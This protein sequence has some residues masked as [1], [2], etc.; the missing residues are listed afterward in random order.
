MLP[1]ERSLVK[2]VLSSPFFSFLPNSLTSRFMCT[3]TVYSSIIFRGRVVFSL[4]IYWP[5]TATVRCLPPTSQTSD[6]TYHAPSANHRSTYC[7]CLGSIT[8]PGGQTVKLPLKPPHRLVLLVRSYG[9]PLPV[10][11]QSCHSVR[12]IPLPGKR[13]RRWGSCAVSRWGPRRTPT[14]PS[15]SSASVANRGVHSSTCPPVQWRLST[16]AFWHL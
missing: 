16:S 6:V 7:R 14:R 3:T 11:C 9:L 15:G 1:S 8:I 13:C 4:R 12:S 5:A 10:W 2:L